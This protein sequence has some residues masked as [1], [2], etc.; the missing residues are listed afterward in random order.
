MEKRFAQALSV[1]FYPL[2]VPT[3]AFAVLLTMPA[4]FS[5]LMPASAKWMIIGLVFSVTCVIPTLSFLFMIKTGV[6]STTY[7]TK[8]EDRTMPYIVSIIFFYLAYY[9]LKKLQVS[10]VY[11]YFMIGATMLNILVFGINFF[12]KIS[13]HMASIGALTGMM[14][15]LSNFLGTFY[16]SFIAITL[17][18]S[19][20]VAFARLK[21]EAHTPAQVYAGFI[22]GFM[23]IISLFLFKT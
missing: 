9:M 10:P 14:V 15:G 16:F 5:A 23:T 11:V 21:L 3:Y 7:L 6:V 8:R 2:F 22:L 18:V 12:W 13:S 4:Y 1:I 20:F 17:I 19:G